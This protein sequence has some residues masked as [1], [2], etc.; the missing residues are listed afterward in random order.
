M[1]NKVLWVRVISFSRN[2]AG[3]VLNNGAFPYDEND[4]VKEEFRENCGIASINGVVKLKN[5][6]TVDGVVQVIGY[7]GKVTETTPDKFKRGWSDL[8]KTNDS[9]TA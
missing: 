8:I 4:Y 2:K 3:W 9:T 1:T 6:L 7:S 5:Q